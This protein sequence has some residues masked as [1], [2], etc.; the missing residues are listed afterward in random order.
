MQLRLPASLG[1]QLSGRCFNAKVS[2]PVAWRAVCE[3]TNRDNLLASVH[4]FFRVSYYLTG[5]YFFT[6]QFLSM[7]MGFCAFKNG[8]YASH[9]DSFALVN[10]SEN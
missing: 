4:R 2:E 8:E 1:F 10:R 9:A 6:N 5:E 7:L 3:S